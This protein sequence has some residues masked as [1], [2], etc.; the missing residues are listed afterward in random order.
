MDTPEAINRFQFLQVLLMYCL[1][2]G[3]LVVDLVGVAEVDTQ[4]V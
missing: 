3:A 4:V 2:Y 1:K